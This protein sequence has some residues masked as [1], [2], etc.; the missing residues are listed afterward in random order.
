[1][2]GVVS[3]LRKPLAGFLAFTAAFAVLAA[4]V[5]WG[6]WSM[7]FS[8]VMPDCPIVHP[9]T[10]IAD[11]WRTWLTN[12][13]FVP[14]DLRVFLGTPYFWQELNY[15]IALYVSALALAYFLR[16]R[17]LSRLASY[18]AGLTLAF[19]GYWCT[20]FSAGHLG[21][22]LWMTY[23]LFPFGLLDRAVRKGK[24]KNWL[25]AGATAGWACCWQSDLWM[26]FTALTAAY[27][28][29]CCV[30]ERAFPWKGALLAAAT[31]F[32]VGGA[33]IR[34]AFVSDLA[35]RDGQIAAGETLPKA[36]ADD[37]EKRWEF[38]TNWSLPTAETL[39][40][41]VPRVNGD[42]SCSLTLAIGSQHHSGVRPYTGAL[43]RPMRATTGNYRQHSLYLGWVT[44]LLA[45]VGALTGMVGRR[46]ARASAE[47]KVKTDST[48][49]FFVVAAVLCWLFSQGR[50]CETVYR[51]VYALP[52]GDYLRAPVKWHHL[53]EFCVVVLMGY[54]LEFLASW[55]GKWGSWGRPAL[56]ALVLFGA[57]D[58]ARNAHLY[59]A[60]VDIREAR[61]QNCSQQM[62]YLRRGDFANPKVAAMVKAKR[63]VPLAQ[64]AADIYLVGVLEPW[65]A[66]KEPPPPWGWA[67][68]LGALSA[69]VS[70]L[71]I[72]FSVW[73]P[74]LKVTK[75]ST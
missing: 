25:L 53:T 62:A 73:S 70:L 57:F 72:G 34:N 65:G 61:R 26:L 55:L 33:G 6:T 44:C 60:P 17:G 5:F 4:Y 51:M 27:F 24:A 37:G 42:T 71:V 39:E 50:Y 74:R 1:M 10:W 41:L 30:R 64:P 8:P 43:G 16:G 35:S 52:F 68:S 45:L 3:L 59:C 31:F 63:I 7:D 9:P 40:F 29:F 36:A 13:K 46:L 21:W 23:G 69:A 28:V 66:N 48:P 12:G 14:S 49:V 67:A 11:W 38:V 22:F 20:L 56:A 18:G 2:A 15:A 58:L 75:E 19:C 47:G 32:L 54:G